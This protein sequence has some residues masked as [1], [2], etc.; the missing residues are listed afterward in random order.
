MKTISLVAVTFCALFSGLCN[1][2]VLDV[3][4]NIINTFGD[5]VPP[6]AKLDLGKIRG[7]LMTS[8]LGKKIL[9][10]RGVR[11]AE[12]P[13]NELRFKVSYVHTNI[14]LFMAKFKANKKNFLF[15]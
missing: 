6:I 13:I 3:D 1:S 9:A 4:N 14:E 8:R 11:Y 2:Y 10:F 5:D 15:N 7:N 12:P